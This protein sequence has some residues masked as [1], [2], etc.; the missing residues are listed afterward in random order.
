[1]LLAPAN[2][3][4]G[5]GLGGKLAGLASLEG[6][7]LGGEGSNQPVISKEVL[8]SRT[9]LTIFIYRHKLTQPLMAVKGWDIEAQR[10]L[11]NCEVYN[12]DSGEW[13]EGE[14]GKSLKS[15]DWG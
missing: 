6:I 3:E 2:D 10:W 4:D 9:F 13:L 7:S 11:Y 14:D 1:M 12:P 15:I 8:Q 5:K